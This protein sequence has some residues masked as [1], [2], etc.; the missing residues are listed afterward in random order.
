[1]IQLDLFDS[2]VTTV[3]FDEFNKNCSSFEWFKKTTRLGIEHEDEINRYYGLEYDWENPPLYLADPLNATITGK[4][5]FHCIRILF[6]DGDSVL[7]TYRTREFMH[8][9][10]QAFDIP[11]SM[12]RD[13]SHSKQV[14]DRM[15]ANKFTTFFFKEKYRRYFDKCYPKEQYNDYY[16][17]LEQEQALHFENPR[18]IKKHGIRRLVDD[19]RYCIVDIHGKK[20]WSQMALE[21]RSTW[22]A[23]KHSGTKTDNER[24][25]FENSLSLDDSRI[26]ELAIVYE[27]RL[28]LA[29]KTILVYDGYGVDIMFSHV[30]RDKKQVLS[31][32]DGISNMVLSNIDECMRYSTGRFLLNRGIKREYRLGFIPGNE[33]LHLH[34]ER[35]TSGKIQYFSTVK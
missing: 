5:I 23:S 10:V 21:C 3:T 14:I 7:M 9:R 26:A 13:F 35:I 22:F 1:M 31:E 16:Y 33:T 24:K 34:K 15:L 20:E 11:I 29:V 8:K 6:N 12:N 19:D 25:Y 28:I 4:S 32:N 27:N 30:A 18:W 17:D 2:S